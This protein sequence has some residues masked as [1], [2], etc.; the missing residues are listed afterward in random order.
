LYPTGGDS[1]EVSVFTRT[2]PNQWFT[3][4]VLASDNSLAVFVNGRECSVWTD[5][6]RRFTS[7]HIVLQ[8]LTPTTVIEFRSI[9]VL[10][11]D[12]AK[13]VDSKEVARLLGHESRVSSVAFS[14]DGMRVLSGGNNHDYWYND[15]GGLGSPFGGDNTVRLWNATSGRNILTMPG[16]EPEIRSVAFS[17]DGK[18]AVS[19]GGWYADLPHQWAEVWDLATGRRLHWLRREKPEREGPVKT[20]MFSPNGRRILAVFP[21]GTVHT[22]DLETEKEQDRIQFKGGPVAEN[23]FPSVALTSDQKRLVTGTRNGLV[24]TWNLANGDR[25][26]MLVGHAEAVGLVRWS[27]DGRRVLSGGSDGMIRLWDVASGKP[28]QLLNGAE[29]G[30]RSFAIS[31]DGR[32]ALTGGNYGAIRLWD[33]DSGRLSGRLEGHAMRVNSVAFSPDGQLAISGSDDKTARTWRL[34][35]PTAP[36]PSTIGARPVSR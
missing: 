19:S 2:P 24:E 22:W 1:E 20:A 27:A 10:E 32:R 6:G 23:E 25:Q 26:Q 30:L 11:S 36:A 18:Y 17:P 28:L 16:H 3:M 4:D 8:Q 34:P 35:P 15:R 7:G 13:R 9:A 21:N 12:H 31:P 5:K 14:P 29:D 33:L